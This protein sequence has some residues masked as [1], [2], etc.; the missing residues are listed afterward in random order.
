MCS[1]I[2]CKQQLEVRKTP[3]K[4]VLLGFLELEEKVNATF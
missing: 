4:G 1:K 2:I 3:F